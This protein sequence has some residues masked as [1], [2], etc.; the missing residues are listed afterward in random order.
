MSGKIRV[1]EKGLKNRLEFSFGEFRILKSEMWI[2]CEG[3]GLEN[4]GDY[5][6]GVKQ[7]KGNVSRE[8][9]GC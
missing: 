4:L 1:S 7:F 2:L 6:W 9:K 3:V 5:N 8:T